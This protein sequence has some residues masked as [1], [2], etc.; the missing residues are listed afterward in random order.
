MNNEGQGT[1]IVRYING[2]EQRF[3]Y[4]REDD[5]LNIASRIQDAL[6]A[7]QL[8]IELEDS[9]MVIPFQNVQSIKIS[10]SPPKLPPIAL[11]NVRLV[12]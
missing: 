1:L 8:L 12:S 6:N 5:T 2:E 11:K 4:P 3:E 10:P 9:V 7:N